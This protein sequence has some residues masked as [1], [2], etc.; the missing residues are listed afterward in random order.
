MS[1]NDTSRS[2]V[3]QGRDVRPAG[4]FA[5]KD[6]EYNPHKLQDLLDGKFEPVFENNEEFEDFMRVL[7]ESRAAQIYKF[8]A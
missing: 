3:T 5:H 8:P 7:E 6:N 2:L 4:L 1:E